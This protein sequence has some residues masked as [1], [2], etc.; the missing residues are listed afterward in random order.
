MN[1]PQ[2][3]WVMDQE[4]HLDPLYDFL[5]FHERELLGDDLLS[6]L[7][8][9]QIQGSNHLVQDVHHQLSNSE[10]DSCL[11][12]EGLKKLDSFNRWMS[13]ELGDVS[14]SHVQSSSEPYW[15]TVENESGID[16]PNKSSQA[17]LDTYV[18]GPSLSQDQ[19]FSIIDFS[20]NWAYVGSDIKVNLVSSVHILYVSLI[21]IGRIFESK[22]NCNFLL[23]YVW[24]SIC[25]QCNR[26]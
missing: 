16:Y 14:E 19:L 1:P 9:S 12:G 17:H 2:P 5:S 22:L 8:L 15:D 25:L 20:P 11:S 21:S 10:T 18:L 3:K 13:R 24:F 26:F 23:I 7:G 4:F 6:T